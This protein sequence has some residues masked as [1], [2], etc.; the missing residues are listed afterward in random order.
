MKT[1]NGSLKPWQELLFAVVVLG[2]GLWVGWHGLACFNDA[3]QWW[4]GRVMD[5]FVETQARVD[6]VWAARV[7][8][9]NITLGVEILMAGSYQ[10][11][12]VEHRF[13]DV[14]EKM[15][16]MYGRGFEGV[17][18]RAKEIQ[19][20]QRM[21]LVFYDPANPSYAV[22]KKD[23]V[24][25][26]FRGAVLG[27]LGG[28]IELVAL[29]LVLMG[30]V[31]ICVHVLPEW[32]RHY[33]RPFRVIY[34]KPKPPKPEP[35]P[36]RK[37]SPLTGDVE[38]DFYSHALKDH[39]LGC[40]EGYYCKIFLMP[41]HQVVIAHDES[42]HHYFRTWSIDEVLAGS[43]GFLFDDSE[44]DQKERESFEQRIQQHHG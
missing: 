32:L 10:V 6:K 21:T 39:A 11:K 16:P 15:R 2:V 26:F 14:E 42:T 7:M 4:R 37:P 27:F 33:L 23:H 38:K 22:L 40:W 35:P 25:G 17:E 24:P 13:V 9:R 5:S 41:D 1:D 31:G 20:T 34:V 43:A 12:G 3:G 44:H 30:L 29:A 36:L 18:A 28:I 19:R 8:S